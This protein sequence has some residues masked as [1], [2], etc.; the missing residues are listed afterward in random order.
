M[1]PSWKG[2][3]KALGSQLGGGRA[4]LGEAAASVSG[5]AGPPTPSSWETQG[6]AYTY[7]PLSL[8]GCFRSLRPVP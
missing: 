2:L 8:S 3:F 6:L 7:T 4:D 5:A 1:R